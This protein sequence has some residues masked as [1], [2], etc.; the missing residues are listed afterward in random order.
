MST[1]NNI[2]NLNVHLDRTLPPFLGSLTF[3][4]MVGCGGQ[5]TIVDSEPNVLTPE[6]IL[7]NLT[8]SYQEKNLDRYMSN[9]SESSIFFDG[10]VKLWDF[11]VERRLHERM[12]AGSRKIELTMQP[13]TSKTVVDGSVQ[14]TYGYQAK[15]V[16][17]SGTVMTASGQVTLILI[18]GDG[19]DWKIVSFREGTSVLKKMPNP[20]QTLQDSV[21]YLPLRVGNSWAYEEQITPNVPDIELVITDSLMLQGNSYHRVQNGEGLLYS[22]FVRMDSLHQLRSFFTDDSTERVVFDFAAEIGDNLI[23]VQPNAPSITVVELFSRKDSITV[24]AGTFVNVIEF[25]ISD[26]SS[27]S[28]SI[29]EFAANVGIIRGQGTNSMLVLKSASVNGNKYPII[30]SVRQS[31]SSWSQMKSTFR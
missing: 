10:G 3:F 9:F 26:F 2:R 20:A 23:F 16:R 13:I 11:E 18:N 7:E 25:V 21:D 14:S 29:C 12:F 24:P 27:G 30:T 31:G 4:I 1:V 17:L 5:P 6:G 8:I 22:D 15:L 28:V 19:N